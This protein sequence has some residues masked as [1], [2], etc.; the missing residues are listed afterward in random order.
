MELIDHLRTLQTAELDA[1]VRPVVPFGGMGAIDGPPPG[2]AGGLL[3]EEEI[4]ALL[5]GAGDADLRAALDAATGADV[6]WTT[7]HLAAE[8]ERR[9]TIR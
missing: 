9:R 4:A 3:V 5:A 1:L 8:I 6:G 2:V 7:N